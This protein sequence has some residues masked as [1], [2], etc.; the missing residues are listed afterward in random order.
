MQSSLRRMSAAAHFMAAKTAAT[1]LQ[2]MYRG[3]AARKAAADPNRFNWLYDDDDE[4]QE[5]CSYPSP[6][7][8]AAQPR[9]ADMSKMPPQPVEPQPEVITTR[10]PDHFLM[11]ARLST[12]MRLTRGILDTLPMV[13]YMHLKSA[14]RK[15]SSMPVLPSLQRQH[16]QSTSPT[17]AAASSGGASSTEQRPQAAQQTPVIHALRSRIEPSRR[18]RR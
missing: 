11:A 14:A 7:S 3:K 16:Q 18:P 15:S 2:A 6:R 13:P 17:T 1:L 12:P 4:K 8:P 5:A 10:A 9:Q